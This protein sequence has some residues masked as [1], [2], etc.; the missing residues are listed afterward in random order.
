[1]SA[2]DGE[3]RSLLLLVVMSFSQHC[4]IEAFSNVLKP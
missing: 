4:G 2:L 1:M 3:E